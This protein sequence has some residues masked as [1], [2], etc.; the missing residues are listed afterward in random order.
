MGYSRVTV[1]SLTAAARSAC[2]A[3]SRP[4]TEGNDLVC[5]RET[6][7]RVLRA[8]TSEYKRRRQN[9]YVCIYIQ[10]SSL[11]FLDSPKP[12][13]ANPKPPIVGNTVAPSRSE[14]RRLD[15]IHTSRGDFS[16]ERSP[17]RSEGAH[18]WCRSAARAFREPVSELLLYVASKKSSSG[19]GVR[20]SLPNASSS[21]DDGCSQRRFCSDSMRAEVDVR[22][23][24]AIMY[25]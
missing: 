12:P 25:R 8:R 6:T 24:R 15:A 16:R 23:S 7:S 4:T 1:A 18:A 13:L 10:S 17:N 21:A 11:S 5:K 3:V 19:H 20:S 2:T 22:A 9:I 14:L